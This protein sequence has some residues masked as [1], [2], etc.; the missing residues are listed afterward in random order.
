MGKKAATT[1]SLTH[2]QTKWLRERSEKTG[3]TQVEI[4]RRALDDYKENEETKEQR[5][6]FTPKQRKDIREVALLK[7]VSEIQIIRSAIDREVRFMAKLQRN[8]KEV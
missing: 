6:F 7:G 5:Q 1:F 8:K 4:V 2:P 3:L